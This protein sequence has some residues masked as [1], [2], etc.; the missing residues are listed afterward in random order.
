M[1]VL[2]FACF[3]IVLIVEGESRFLQVVAIWHRSKR[4]LEILSRNLASRLAAPEL[5]SGLEA[6][7]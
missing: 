2:L 1:N 6:D 3:H 5:L 7:C 4:L